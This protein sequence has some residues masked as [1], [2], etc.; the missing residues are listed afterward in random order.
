[1]LDDRAGLAADPQQTPRRLRQHGI[2]PAE[3]AAAA[4]GRLG[5]PSTAAARS[6]RAGHGRMC[7]V[8]LAV[9][10]QKGGV[11][12]GSWGWVWRGVGQTRMA[13][14]STVTIVPVV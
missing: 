2:Q 13:P 14:P 3:P 5:E 8:L 10:G 7:G 11:L 9:A 12:V 1:V 4:C 6:C